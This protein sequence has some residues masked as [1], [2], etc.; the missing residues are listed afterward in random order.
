MSI[1]I[2]V[3]SE[4]DSL[5]GNVQIISKKYCGKAGVGMKTMK[6]GQWLVVAL[7]LITAVVAGCGG[8]GCD[9]WRRSS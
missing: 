2:I 3:N 6:N 8:G 7:V 1:E 4:Y 9:D 5:K